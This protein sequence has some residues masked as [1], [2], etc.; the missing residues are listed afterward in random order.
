[1]SGL[2]HHGDQR[3]DNIPDDVAV[4]ITDADLDGVDGVISNLKQRAQEVAAD[5]DNGIKL[6]SFEVEAAQGILEIVGL[7][8]KVVNAKTIAAGKPAQSTGDLR[9]TLLQQLGSQGDLNGVIG[10]LTA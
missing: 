9:S 10:L 2:A 8:S 3:D 6:A 4:P 5:L 7:L 1:M